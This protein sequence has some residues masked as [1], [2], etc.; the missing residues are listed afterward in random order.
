MSIANGRKKRV[1]HNQESR[2]MIWSANNYKL[3]GLALG[4]L[5]V[6]F[7][8]MYI[9]N[10]FMGWFSLYVSPLLLVSGFVTVVFAVM[11]NFSDDPEQE[12]A[13]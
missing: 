8:G 13:S 6:G 11:K 4:F 3:F 1:Q 7:G 9:E 10:S 12:S 2:P 5:A